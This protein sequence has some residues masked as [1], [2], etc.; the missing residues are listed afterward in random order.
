[1]KGSF[2]VITCVTGEEA[3]ASSLPLLA[4]GLVYIEWEGQSGVWPH[5]EVVL[6]FFFS[7]PLL[8]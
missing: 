1:M 3:S 6:L 4:Q 5:T 2:L 7:F 8:S